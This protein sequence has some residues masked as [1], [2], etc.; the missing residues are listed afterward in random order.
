ML[1]VAISFVDSIFALYGLYRVYSAQRFILLEFQAALLH[2]AWSLYY[3][4]F[5]L[6][7]VWLGSSVGTEVRKLICL[8]LIET[9]IKKVLLKGAY[10]GV[11]IH[12]LI[13]SCTDKQIVDKVDA[14]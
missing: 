14:S 6:T 9:A 1:L 12:K 10:T 13:N 7:I 11:L 3:D 8:R 4:Y 5:I 2:S